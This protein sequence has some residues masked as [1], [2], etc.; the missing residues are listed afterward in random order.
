[1]STTMKEILTGV[2]LLIGM[3]AAA[4]VYIDSNY[5]QAADVAG[6]EQ[7]S[8]KTFQ[9]FRRSLVADELNY[10]YEKESHPDYNAPSWEKSRKK[11][12]ELLWDSYTA[13]ATQ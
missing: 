4:W 10:L 5:A 8:V 2:L 12:L 9:D 11:K 3:L 7:D 6:L 1:M 13:P